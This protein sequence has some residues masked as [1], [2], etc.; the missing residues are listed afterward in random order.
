MNPPAQPPRDNVSGSRF[1]P[2][3]RLRIAGRSAAWIAAGVLLA[4]CATPTFQNLDGASGSKPENVFR[5][6]PKLAGD[7]R[8]VVVLPMACAASRTDLADGCETLDSV[9]VTEMGKTKKFEVVTVTPEALRKSTGRPGWT[10]TETLPQTFFESLRDSCGCDAVMFSELTAFS[11]YPPL[12]VGLRLKLVDASTRQILWAAEEVFESNERI[13]S[14]AGMLV[15]GAL[16]SADS[17]NKEWLTGHS[18]RQFGQ[19]AAAQLLKTLPDR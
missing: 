15:P 4:G 5:Y 17:A 14:G 9:F 2:R 19:R 7:L 13:D 10:G 16:Q 1:H 6:S 11:A 12:R 3:L 18:P 8:R